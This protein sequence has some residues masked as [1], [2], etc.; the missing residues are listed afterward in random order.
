M[1]FYGSNPS[2]QV[3]SIL[4]RFFQVL[5]KYQIFVGLPPTKR[6]TPGTMSRKVAI[7]HQG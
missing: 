1:E 2:F 3:K 6:D 4:L 7:G 5:M